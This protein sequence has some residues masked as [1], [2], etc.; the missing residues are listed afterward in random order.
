VLIEDPGYA[1]TLYKNK[2]SCFKHN[3]VL[4]ALLVIT[5]LIFYVGQLKM[6]DHTFVGI[7]E[8]L[9]V[10]L[11]VPVAYTLYNLY[12]AYINMKDAK[13]FLEA[14]RMVHV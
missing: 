12:Y 3:L 5:V 9:S 8:M 4:T 10:L 2:I 11:M 14:C 6:I 1:E 7:F 13:E